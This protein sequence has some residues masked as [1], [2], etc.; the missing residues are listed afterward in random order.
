MKKLLTYWAMAVSLA[1]SPALAE[2]KTGSA[3]PDFTATDSI[4][5]KPFSLGDFKGKHVVLEW[6]NFGCPFVK[7]YYSKGDM[8]QLQKAAA[9]EEVVW[10]TINSSA[11]GLEG[12][13]ADDAA[14][15]QALT[16]RNASPAHFVRDETGAIGKHYAAK[17]TPHMYVIDAK[18]TLVYQG[19]IDS[20]PSAAQSDIA[21][22]TN[23]VTQ[24]LAELKAGKPVS[25]PSTQPYGCSV[26][27]AN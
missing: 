10:I 3:A 22:A 19:A 7:K 1:A 20:K 25:V 13:L 11:T 27:Y 24:A 26:K 16:E 12:H 4:S 8:Q 2:V 14:A 9:K 18:G 5:G 6:T 15:K 17:T 21:N 23:Y